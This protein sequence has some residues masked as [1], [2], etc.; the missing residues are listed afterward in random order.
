MRS[1]VYRRKDLRLQNKIRTV[2]NKCFKSQLYVIISHRSLLFIITVLS[3]FYFTYY[4][5]QMKR[6]HKNCPPGPLGNYIPYIGYLPFLNPTKP[7]ESL[8]ELS[9]KYGNIFSLQM[10]SIFTVILADAALIREAFKRDE[11]SGRAPLYVTHGIFNGNGKKGF[12]EKKK[13]EKKVNHV[14][15]LCVFRLNMY[16]RRVLE[17]ST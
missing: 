1:A 16:R 11:F 4:L 15:I 13:N 8:F 3:A 14:Q 5:F 10:G 9:K 12:N 6:E 17:G 2:Q 7:Y